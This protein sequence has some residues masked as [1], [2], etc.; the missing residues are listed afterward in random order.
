MST[1]TTATN[2]HTHTNGHTQTNGNGNSHTQNADS[3]TTPATP[4]ATPPTTPALTNYINGQF[5]PPLDN[6]YLDNLAP[7]TSTLLCTLPRSQKADVDAAVAA[8]KAAYPAWS[9]TSVEQRAAYLD[10]IADQLEKHFDRL[11]A[12][13]SEDA[14]KPYAAARVI[15]IPRAV[16]NFRFF[17]GAIRHDTTDSHWMA[18]ALNVTQRCPI[19][20][21]ALITPWNLPVYLLSW[22]V[23]PALAMGNTVVCKPSEL[24]P[25]TADAL[26]HIIHDVGLPPGV[27]NLVHG[28]G[29]EVGQSLVEHED[30]AIVS[31]TGGTATGKRVALSAAPSFKKVSLELGGKNSTIVFADCDYEKTVKAAVRASF[32]NA[33]QV[34]LCGS[35]VLVEQSIYE[36]FVNDYVAEVEKYTVG[37]PATAQIGSLTSLAHREK[38]EYYVDLAQ[39]EGGTIR[40]GGRRPTNLHPP[41]DAGAFYLPTVITGLPPTA[42]CSVEEIFGPVVTVHPFSSEEEALSIAN[43]VRYGL[44]GSLFTSDV[45]RVQRVT[46]RWE[47]GMVWVNTWLH[48]DLRVPFGGVKESGLGAEGGRHSLE[49]W[50]NAKNICFF[51]GPDRL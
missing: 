22:K 8:A 31:F 25:M 41:F 38:I 51:M 32:T 4:P 40:C 47:T 36:R 7:A 30:V 46:R 21:A 39:K 24:T 45:A 2:G 10:A 34:C 29:P 26:A 13:E 42:R 17:A 48:R 35:R 43:G 19:G 49:F 16:K 5:L 14:G 50:S 27:F 3:S 11:A 6:K 37:D 44:A 9:A 23:A 18:D 1:S 15:D 28:L 33:G 20:V 12:M